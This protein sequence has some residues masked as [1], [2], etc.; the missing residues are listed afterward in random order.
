[1]TEIVTLAD[2]IERIDVLPKFSPE[3]RRDMKNAVQK[4]GAHLH[5][6]RNLSLVPARGRQ[7]M[8]AIEA[9]T[10]SQLGLA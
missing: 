9:V 5:D 7:A 3:Q 1:M 2:V 6:S 8:N 10:A 4:I